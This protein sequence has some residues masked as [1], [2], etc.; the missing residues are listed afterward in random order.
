M[1]S[2]YDQETEKERA[3]E[4]DRAK[5]GIQREERESGERY[6]ERQRGTD[7]G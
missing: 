3:R 6:I 2:K 1:V 4:G 7:R 5:E